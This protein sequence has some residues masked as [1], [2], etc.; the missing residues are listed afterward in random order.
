M[1]QIDRLGFSLCAA[2]LDIIMSCISEYMGLEPWKGG[3][4]QVGEQRSGV[5]RTGV[6]WGQRG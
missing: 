1:T 2:P 4:R 5:F 6:G 3:V